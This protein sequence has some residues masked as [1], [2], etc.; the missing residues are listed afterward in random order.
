[1]IELD[2]ETRTAL[3]QL[4]R[5]E[6]DSQRY[7]KITVILMFDSGF[8]AEDIANA[9]GLDRSTI[10]RYAE[11]YQNESLDDYLL[12]F[13]SGSDCHLTEEQRAGLSSELRRRLYRTGKEIAAWIKEEF[14][15]EYSANGA[16][17]LVKGLG[18]V[19]KKTRLHSPEA[20]ES[21][22]EAFV[23]EFQSLISEIAQSKSGDCVY[24]L[25][26]VHPQHATRTQC[27]WIPA[28]EEFLVLSN[29]GRERVNINGALNALDVTDIVVREDR[30][31][32][33]DSTRQLYEMLLARNLEGLVY[34]ICDNAGY[35][36]NKGLAEWVSKS[37]IRQIFLPT[38]SPNLNVIERLW[39]FMRKEVLDSKYYPT[40]EGFREAILKFFKNI[41]NYKAELES[42]LTLNF[43]IPR[44]SQT[45][46]T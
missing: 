26:A 34:V 5:R 24:F 42:L 38:Y 1:M 17:R 23:E 33:A 9:F 45:Q 12:R 13:Y 4:Q 44:I 16:V 8:S 2:T 15:V 25:D 30:S 21:E 6:K 32:N 10:Y 11:S 14:C 41:K 35:Y 18:F 39:K 31:I 40:K 3:R 36:R 43:H 29:T 28:G 19:Y 20:N 27:G 7:M 37:R 46:S 22:Q